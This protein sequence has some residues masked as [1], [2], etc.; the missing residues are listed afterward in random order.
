MY[1]IENLERFK[2]FIFDMDGTLFDTSESNYWSYHDAAQRLG[3]E[4]EHDKFMNVFVGKNYR[5]FLPMFGI[6]SK[7]ELRDIHDY[8]KAHYR[9]YIGKIKMNDELFSL[10]AKMKSGRKI[11]LATTASRLNTMDILEYFDVSDDFDC[12]L[13]QEDVNKLKPD[14]E[15]Y[16]TIMKKLQVSP[17]NTVI[18]EDSV[19]GIEAANASGAVCVKVDDFGND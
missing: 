12:I 3:Y 16:N 10:I 2:L 1:D 11:A 18:F 7:E 15:C 17:T 6:E 14:P 5:E 19:V 8:K 13:T 9:E 4:I